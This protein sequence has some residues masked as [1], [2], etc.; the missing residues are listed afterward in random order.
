[1][2]I[3]LGRR[4]VEPEDRLIEDLGAESADLVNLAAAIDDCYGI[5]LDEEALA[6]V[7]T[8]ADLERLVRAHDRGGR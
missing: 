7:K 1:M 8:V 4:K 2:S 6:E 3:Q 5:Y